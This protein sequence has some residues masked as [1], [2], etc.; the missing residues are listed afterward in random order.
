MNLRDKRTLE[1]TL[2]AAELEQRGA[3]LAR[4]NMD[5]HQAQEEKKASTKTAND[6]IKA[7]E[8]EMMRLSRA[9]K[10]RKEEREVECEW[11]G[12]IS[13][14]TM[15][16][17]RLDTGEEVGSRPMTKEEKEFYRQRP[18]PL[19]QPLALPAAGPVTPEAPV[20]PL[21]LEG[22]D[23]YIADAEFEEVG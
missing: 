22:K 21:Q 20:L 1:C 18:L 14:E 13:T 15:R 2:T 23:N 11:Q 9:V 12:F 17:I 5:W 3:A 8:V 6:A 7:H 10:T 16:Q 4:T 19:V